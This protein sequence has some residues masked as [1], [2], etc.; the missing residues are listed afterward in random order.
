MRVLAFQLHMF[1]IQIKT[2]TSHSLPSSPQ[3]V[4]KAFRTPS[5]L[6]LAATV[7]ARTASN[8]KGKAAQNRLHVH[9]EAKTNVLGFL[10]TKMSSRIHY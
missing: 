6:F 3:V 8:V 5:F 2:H 7:L 10:E 9:A 1:H 4:I